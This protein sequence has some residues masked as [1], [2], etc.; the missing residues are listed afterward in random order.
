MT[1]PRQ[2][3]AKEAQKGSSNGLDR[4][5]HIPTIAALAML[6][7]SIGRQNSGFFYVGFME[8]FSINRSDASWPNSVTSVLINLSGILLWL[9]RCRLSAY[10]IT[11]I[12]SIFTW[13][14]IVASAFAPSMQWTTATLGAI[15]G[16]GVGIVTLSLAYIN[17]LYFDQ[18]RGIACGVKFAGVYLASLIFPPALVYFEE[19]Y[20]FRG[21]LLL[22]GAITMHVT[23]FCLPLNVPQ[24]IR[25]KTEVPQPIKSMEY[26]TINGTQLSEGSSASRN[27]SGTNISKGS[28]SIRESVRLLRMPVYYAIVA[29][30]VIADFAAMAFQSTI[31]DY[32]I[33]KGFPLETAESIVVYSSVAQLVGC[34]IVPLLADRGFMNRSTL[35]VVNL[36]VFGCS[37]L[38]LPEVEKYAYV[39]IFCLCVA[40][41]SAFLTAIKAAIITDYLG[42]D[43]IPLCCALLGLSTMPLFLCNPTII[44]VFRDSKGS[45]DNYYRLHGGLQFFA[46]FI[47]STVCCS[48]GKSSR[49]WTPK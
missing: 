3:L 45:Y 15:Y 2:P 28:E 16:T 49:S 40:I 23:A 13:T 34:L 26:C 17:I 42:A 14:G 41:S 31:V 7:A 12:G 37:L 9:L 10:Q 32:S 24:W 46:G 29:Y 36:I 43:A 6:A 33:D 8:V 5:W 25:H 39:L 22:S 21:A 18:Y 4:C 38:I 19:A 27:T 48:D 30:T 20:G 11:L 47:F 44:G 1:T 35:I